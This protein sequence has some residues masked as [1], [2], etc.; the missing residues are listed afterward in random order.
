MLLKTTLIRF[1]R[2]VHGTRYTVQGARQGRASRFTVHRAPCTLYRAP[3]ALS[4]L[5]LSFTGRA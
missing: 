1:G 4:G 5:L 3:F 2:M